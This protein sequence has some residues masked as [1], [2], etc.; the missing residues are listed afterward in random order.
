MKNARFA[1]I[2]PDDGMMMLAGHSRIP[3]VVSRAA[4]KAGSRSHICPILRAGV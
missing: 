3:F 2:D 1:V 4:E